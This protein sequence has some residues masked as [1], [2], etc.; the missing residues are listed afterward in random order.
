[1]QLVISCRGFHVNEQFEF[2]FSMH[3]ASV[4]SFSLI[5]SLFVTPYLIINYAASCESRNI[6][7]C[8]C[9]EFEVKQD[10]NNSVSSPLP[11]FFWA[12]FTASIQ[13]RRKIKD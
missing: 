12:K 11:A 7:G 9:R 13:E 1:M 3:S 6:Y 5:P 4:P 10:A 2:F 8:F